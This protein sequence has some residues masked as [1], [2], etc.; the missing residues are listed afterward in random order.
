MS[1]VTFSHLTAISKRAQLHASKDVLMWSAWRRYWE[2]LKPL[3]AA[4]PPP[5][6]K[7]EQQQQPQLE[8]RKEQAAEKPKKKKG[9]EQVHL[10][11]SESDDDSDDTSSSS[12]E[13]KEKEKKERLSREELYREEEEKKE[14]PITGGGQAAEAETVDEAATLDEE[15]GYAA[16]LLH[17]ALH[18]DSSAQTMPLRQVRADSPISMRTTICHSHAIC[19]CNSAAAAA[20]RCGC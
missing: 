3:W 20:R 1:S 14:R 11:F 19:V 17:A 2:R 7:Q 10:A 13:E 4:T 15:S 12:D 9:S 18:N 6:R 5:S 16:Q 8:E